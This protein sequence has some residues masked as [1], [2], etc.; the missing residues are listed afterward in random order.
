MLNKRGVLIVGGILR[1]E[2]GGGGMLGVEISGGINWEI[3]I[4][5]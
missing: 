2:G 5:R 4:E 1:V 3:H